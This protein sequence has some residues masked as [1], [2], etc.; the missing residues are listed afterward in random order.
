MKPNSEYNEII[1]SEINRG[2]D[3]CEIG[4]GIDQTEEDLIK[5]ESRLTDDYFISCY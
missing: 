4:E 3:I 5:L 2:I 1:I